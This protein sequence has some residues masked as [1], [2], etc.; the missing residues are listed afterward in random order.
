MSFPTSSTL[1]AP[2]AA[3]DVRTLNLTT[4]GHS[5][6]RHGPVAASPEPRPCVRRARSP[7][8]GQPGT[9][10]SRLA[11]RR[12]PDPHESPSGGRL[13]RGCST[14]AATPAKGTVRFSP[15]PFVRARREGT[16]FCSIS[17]CPPVRELDTRG[18]RF[19]A[20]SDSVSR[21]PRGR[22]RPSTEFPRAVAFTFPDEQPAER[23]REVAARRRGEGNRDVPWRT[24]PSLP[25]VEEVCRTERDA[26]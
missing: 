20:I 11:S 19:T 23:R 21:I 4:I 6:L 24:E 8:P 15:S 1:Q 7:R 22:R 18:E 5:L 9:R 17:P 2:P 13:R 3:V 10:S 26:K 16:P 14:A 25:A 12:H